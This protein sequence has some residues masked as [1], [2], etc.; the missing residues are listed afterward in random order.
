[1]SANDSSLS[2]WLWFAAQVVAV[3]LLSAVALWQRAQRARRRS[4]ARQR[5]AAAT[6]QSARQR[7]EALVQNGSFQVHAGVLLLFVVVFDCVFAQVND[8]QCSSHLAG[9]FF[10]FWRRQSGNGVLFVRDLSAQSRVHLAFVATDELESV[11]A[12]RRVP[13]DPL[14]KTMAKAAH[15][16]DAYICV[17][18]F[19]ESACVIA[20]R[21]G[22]QSA[23]KRFCPC[24]QSH[25]TLQTNRFCNSCAQ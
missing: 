14:Y 5:P 9:S 22:A 2:A 20:L 15:V 21:I 8:R 3:L 12:Q 23:A 6:Q 16:Q 19:G 17:F 10:D 25:A 4:A 13:V 18:Q 11:C 7:A 24:A 1:M